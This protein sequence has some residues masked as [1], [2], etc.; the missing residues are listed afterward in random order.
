M[1]IPR[2]ASRPLKSGRP[3]AA[4]TP[5]GKRMTVMGYTASE[6]SHTTGIYGRTLSEYLSGRAELLDHHLSAL[7]E[8]LECDPDDLLA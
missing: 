6:L 8:A 4:H 5:L 7:A 3:F 2:S 1:P